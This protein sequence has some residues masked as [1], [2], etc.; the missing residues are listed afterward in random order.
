MRTF[1]ATKEWS[2]LLFLG[3]LAAGTPVLLQRNGR[4]RIGLPP[5]DFE[6]GLE[7]PGRE[8]SAKLQVSAK[9][10]M[11]RPHG[12]KLGE[13][14]HFDLTTEVTFDCDKNFDVS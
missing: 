2:A 14:S 7:H 8:H 12:N 1:S 11:D 6:G 4:A 10:P 13:T 9:K 5:R 3:T